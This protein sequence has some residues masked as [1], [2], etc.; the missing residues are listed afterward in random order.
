MNTVHCRALT[1]FHSA[2]FLKFFCSFSETSS[3]VWASCQVVH[4]LL[5]QL[6]SSGDCWCGMWSC[7]LYLA[8]SQPSLL[9]PGL[10]PSTHC[11]HCDPIFIQWVFWLIYKQILSLWLN[12][13]LSFRMYFTEE[14]MKMNSCSS[15]VCTALSFQYI[16]QKTC[17]VLALNH[18]WCSAVI[19]LL[20]TPIRSIIGCTPLTD[21]CVYAS[22]LEEQDCEDID[23]EKYLM[24]RFCLAA[25]VDNPSDSVV[26]LSSSPIRECMWS[27]HILLLLSCFRRT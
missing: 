20:D 12:C 17:R 18:E 7:W 6:R 24:H 13:Y 2:L 15:W 19:S 11:Q 3:T 5:P 22:F 4:I 21:M 16:L 14:P 25:I 1:H 27:F 26:G 8:E 10:S 23:C 9:W